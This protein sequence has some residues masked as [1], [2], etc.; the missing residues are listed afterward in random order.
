MAKVTISVTVLTVGGLIATAA[1]AMAGV[2]DPD[3]PVLWVR[4]IAAFKLGNSA[5]AQANLEALIRDHADTAAIQIAA[6]YA[7]AAK[8]DEAFAWLRRAREQSDPGLCTMG[9]L[10]LFDSLKAD[11]RW[12]DFWG[13]MGVDASDGKMRWK[14]DA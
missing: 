10:F 13:A 4:S 8:K 14:K 12:V 5:E 3:W 2:A 7:V 6:C 11:K 1:T 9:R